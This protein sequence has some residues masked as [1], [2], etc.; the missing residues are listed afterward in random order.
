[1]TIK[2]SA[3]GTIALEGACPI[4]DAELLQ[5]QLL[6]HPAAAVDWRS[7]RAAHTA[8]VQVLLAAHP[9]LVGPPASSF[10]RTHVEPLLS[11]RAS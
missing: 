10:L 4:E 1:M 2:L 8:V 9:R 7:C 6:A 11:A 5:R 3:D